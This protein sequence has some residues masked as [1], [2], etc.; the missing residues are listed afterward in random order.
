M[1]SV[2]QRSSAACVDKRLPVVLRTKRTPA[3]MMRAGSGGQGCREQLVLRR[4][5][6]PFVA[7]SHD[8]SNLQCAVVVYR[9]VLRQPG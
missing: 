1:Q 2:K 8:S 4:Q 5:Y 7:K 3:S 6:T 9:C